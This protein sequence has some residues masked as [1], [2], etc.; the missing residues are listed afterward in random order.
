MQQQIGKWKL[1]KNKKYCIE[2]HLTII[3]LYICDFISTLD[4]IMDW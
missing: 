2:N 1:Q 3:Y 4:G